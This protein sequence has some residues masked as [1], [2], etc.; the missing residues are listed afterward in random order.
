MDA[1]YHIAGRSDWEQ[2]RRDGAYTMSTRGL[3][4]AEQGFIHCSTA[5]QVAGVANA[6][7]RGATGLVLL[8]IDPARVRP[9]IQ[10]DDVPGEPEPY[11]HIYG[12]LNIDAVI[13]V[14][15]FAP[16]GTGAFSFPGR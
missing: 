9:K 5:D 12:P 14:R 7:Y 15:P 3:T 2:A 4:L 1:I 6:F 13:E 8:V 11:P 16:D 10:H